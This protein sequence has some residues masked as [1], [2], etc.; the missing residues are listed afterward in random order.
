MFYSTDARHEKF[1]RVGIAR[2]AVFSIVSWLRGLAKAGPKSGSCEGSAAQDVDKICTTPALESDLEVKIVKNWR[3]RGT[4]GSGTSQNLHQ[5]KSVKPGRFGALAK[6]APRLCATAIS[7]SKSLKHRGF[8]P[9]ERGKICTTP[10]RDGD[11]TVNIVKAPWVGALLEV[12][13]RKICAALRTR[14]VWK[15]KSLKTEG[16]GLFL[17]VENA[18][19]AAGAGISTRCKLP[20]RRRSS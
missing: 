19:R 18:F 17:E 5:S 3:R 12:E 7:P 20:G 2:N 11:F 15:S 6:F 9:V 10:A 13:L 14:A 16:V 4:F 8:G 1:W